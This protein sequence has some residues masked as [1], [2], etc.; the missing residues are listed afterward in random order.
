MKRKREQEEQDVD[1]AGIDDQPLPV[2]E[3]DAIGEEEEARLDRVWLEHDPDDDVVPD[4]FPPVRMD[5][6]GDEEMYM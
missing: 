4:F 3:M 1:V 6:Y 5:D 2:A